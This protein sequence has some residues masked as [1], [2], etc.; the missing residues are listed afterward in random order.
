MQT[1]ETKSPVYYRGYQVYP[2]W[3]TPV[4]DFIAPI[5]SPTELQVGVKYALYESGECTWQ[6]EYSFRGV[7]GSSFLFTSDDLLTGGGDPLRYSLTELLTA[8]ADGEIIK[9][10][11]L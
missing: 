5:K 8:I 7:S 6:A 2:D 3:V 4:K 1:K 10:K 9:Q 11:Q